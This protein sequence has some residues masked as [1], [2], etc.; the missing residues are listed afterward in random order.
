MTPANRI[1]ELLYDRGGEFVWM[2][3]LAGAVGASPPAA[4]AALAELAGRG[5]RLQRG[6]EGVRLLRPTVLDAHLIERGLP[7]AR[8]GRHVICFDEVD[9]TNDVA[10][11]S[12]EGAGG[13]ALVV[14]AEHQRAGRGRL[15]RRWVCERGAGVLASVLLPAGSERLPR[16]GLTVAAGLAVAEGLEAAAGVRTGLAWPNDVLLDGGKVAGVL[17]DVRSPARPGGSGERVVVGMGINA[18]G[19]PPPEQVGRATACLA[20]AAGRAVE[21]IDVLRAVLVALDRRAADLAAGRTAELHDAWAA[22]SETINRRVAVAGPDGRVE[23]RVLD[24]S[25]TEGLVLLTDGG[26]RV[27]LPA[28]TSTLIDG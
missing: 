23:G 3:E 10:L 27:H 22:R 24:V 20:A 13:Q 7:V 26:R 28:A 16:E 17:V 25:P 19:A 21:R 8:I 4:E 1:L 6:P 11:D 9:S 18:G 2:D 15:G 5:H 12:A 14:T